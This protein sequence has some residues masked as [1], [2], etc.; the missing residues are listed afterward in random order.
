MTVRG[1]TLMERK[2][3]KTVCIQQEHI[4]VFLMSIDKEE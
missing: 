4:I 1:D 3:Q 2:V